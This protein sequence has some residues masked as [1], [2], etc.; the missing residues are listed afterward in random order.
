MSE[1]L[2]FRSEQIVKL[3]LRAG[4][5]TMEEILAAAGSSA[6]S[7]R[8]DLARLENR[9]LIRRTHGGATLAE[10]LLYEPFRYDS[11]FLAREQRFAAEKRKIGLAAAELVQAGETVGLSAGTTTTYIGR[12]LRH[13]EKIQIITNAINIGMELCN[14]P[15]I[16]TYLTGGVV[17]WAWSFSLTGNAALEFLDDVYLDKVFLSVT[18][19][20]VERGAT[21]LEQDEALV[22]R[23]MLKQSKQVIVVADSSK[24]DKVGPAL[25]CPTSEIH[26]L[27]TDAGATA[28]ALSP[29]ERH[30]IRVIRV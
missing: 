10:P 7:I 17:P 19:L 28:A 15:G 3:L 22:Y 4:S 8:R 24:L 30:G 26:I 13:R 11:S 20:D 1:T 23:K 5:A 18:G 2:N 27:I 14:Q 21:S 16:R 29:F 12:S 9:G 6:P 25:I